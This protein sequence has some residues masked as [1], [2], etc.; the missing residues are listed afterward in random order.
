[1]PGM[2]GE[3]LTAAGVGTWLVEEELSAAARDDK[4]LL[5]LDEP[6]VVRPFD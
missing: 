3:L 4:L 5:L 2:V 6:R 1:M